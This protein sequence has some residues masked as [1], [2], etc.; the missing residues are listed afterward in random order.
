[1][2]LLFSETYLFNTFYANDKRW[3]Q[4]LQALLVV[5]MKRKGKG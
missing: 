1:M 2:I 3:Q 4:H 5:Q